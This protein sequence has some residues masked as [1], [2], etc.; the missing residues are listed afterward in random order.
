[1]IVSLSAMN[2]GYCAE[3]TR[4]FVVGGRRG[5]AVG[6]RKML[7][8]SYDPLVRKLVPGAGLGKIFREFQDGIGREGRAHVSIRGAGLS[9]TD[10][11]EGEK[12]SVSEGQRL[13]ENNVVVFEAR[14]EHP[15][16]GSAQISDTVHVT[17][18]GPSLLTRFQE[19]A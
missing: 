17:G 6:I 3:S 2:D 12:A 10:L 9:L 19:D 18:K 16:H 4:T 11:P 5:K 15:K 7:R 8:D 14:L 1:M 13:E